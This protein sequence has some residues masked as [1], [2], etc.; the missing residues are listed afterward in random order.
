VGGVLK[1]VRR[2]RSSEGA[3]R[4]ALYDFHVHHQG[5][6]VNFGG[7]QLPVLY[8][9]ETIIDS[10]LH[11]RKHSSMFDVSHMLQS[12]IYGKDRVE[13]MES[14][15]VAD[16]KGLPE[17]S[18]ALSLFT[19]KETGGILD[20]LIVTKCQN[21]LYVVSNAGRRDHDIQLMSNAQ[22]QFRSRGKE[23]SIKFFDPE[24]RS[25]LA[26]QGPRSGELLQKVT[27]VDL[28]RL[29]FMQTCEAA[30]KGIKCRL[31]R[32]GYTGEDGFE[33]SVLSGKVNELAS[34][35][36]D[37][38]GNFLKL[39]GLGARDTLRLEAGLCLYGNDIDHT[40][41]PVSAILMWTVGKARRIAA[42]F[43]GAR[44]ILE[45]Q[46]KGPKEKRVGLLGGKEKGPS[47]RKGAV[48]LNEGSE[49]VGRV[50]S[51]CPSPSL[52]TNIAMAYVKADLAKVGTRLNVQVRQGTPPVQMT[53]AKFPLVPTNYYI[54]PKP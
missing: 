35:L 15:C 9:S 24:E 32:C 48:I 28:S 22:D 18:G 37:V 50:T 12:H 44:P 19:D 14:L 43:P 34:A 26:I 40:T 42:D 1:E 52:S 20:D 53:V 45:E 16:I 23:V 51:G 21:H 25:L 17:G 5:K 13:F 6:I 27:D 39:A 4:T 8:G 49:V 36:M 46:R 47:P 31:T 10:H 29:Y 38:E 54:P 3:R 41:T 11:T 7:F 30:I 2:H 33:V